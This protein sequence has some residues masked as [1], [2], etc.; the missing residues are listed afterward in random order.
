[1]SLL[2]AVFSSMFAISGTITLDA[3]Y[4]AF[5][6]QFGA[7]ATASIT[8]ESDGDIITVGSFTVDAGDWISPKSA[9]PGSYEI[10]ATLNS[11]DTPTGTLGSWLALSSNRT[12]TLT[13]P[14]TLL[15]IRECELTIEIGFGGTVLDST[16]VT[17]TAETA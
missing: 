10:R 1:M 17:L 2:A 14:G 8:F 6:L 3:T 16:I 11:G 7:P 4:A 15:G 9:A 13:K 12:W 5:D